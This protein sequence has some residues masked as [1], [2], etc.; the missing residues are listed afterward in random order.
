M[1]DI[2][3][4]IPEPCPPLWKGQV[5]A[6]VVQREAPQGNCRGTGSWGG[7]RVLGATGSLQWDTKPGACQAALVQEAHV[8]RGL[9]LWD[10]TVIQRVESGLKICSYVQGIFGRFILCYPR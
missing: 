5:C 2:H 3:L 6:S 4:C 9:G 7:S 8:T 1:I 10:M